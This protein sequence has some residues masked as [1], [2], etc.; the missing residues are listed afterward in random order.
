MESIKFGSISD[1]DIRKW[2]TEINM[3][4]QRHEVESELDNASNNM[5]REIVEIANY[6]MNV[7]S[8]NEPQITAD[9]EDIIETCI[10][11]GIDYK[12]GGTIFT[13]SSEDIK[14]IAEICEREG[15]KYKDGGTVFERTAKEIDAISDY[16]DSKGINYSRGGTVFVKNLAAIKSVVETCEELGIDCTKGGTIFLRWPDELREIASVCEEYGIEYKSG[17]AAFGKKPGDLRETAKACVECGVEPV[18]LILSTKGEDIR[19]NARF[20]KE[21]YGDEYLERMILAQNPAR[22]KTV[23]PYLEECGCLESLLVGSC[24]ILTLTQQEIEERMEVVKRSGDSILVDGKFH[25]IF[26]QS[27]KKYEENYS[28]TIKAVRD[29]MKAKQKKKDA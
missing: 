27:R 20:I 5:R 28:K 23:L 29:D 3:Y 4:N 25:P 11:C 9:L 26:G 6:L 21:N 15:I 12:Q 24:G 19:E 7:A 17:G 1:D 13:R 16:Y 14:G 10:S 22:L 18:G 8:S 2:Y